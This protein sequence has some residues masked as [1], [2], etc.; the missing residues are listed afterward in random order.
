MNP[1]QDKVVIIT[2]SS[3]G[4]GKS[5]AEKL[6]QRG[7]K[8]V[9]NGRDETALHQVAIQF[10]SRGYRVISVCADVSQ[11]EGCRLV[12]E[13]ALKTYGQVDYLINNAGSNM[14]G[15]IEDV[16]PDALR[17]I[18]DVNYMGALYLTRLALPEL[19]ARKGGVLFISSVAGIHGLPLHGLYSSAKMALRALAEA[20]RAETS[21]SGLYV[22]LA[23]VGLTQNEPG[24]TI[25]DIN[26]NPIPKVDTKGFKLQPIHQVADGLIHMME[27]RRFIRVFTFLGKLTNI[28]NRISPTFVQFMLTQAYKKRGW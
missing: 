18:M 27:K 22:G 17:L 10:Q 6:A 28:L 25:Y 1:F 3:K 2:G 14:Q 13:T 20:L 15:K 23:Y 26:G 7:A 9:L 16:Q 21:D 11:L 4:I 24:K 19:K 12:L 5:L 8:V